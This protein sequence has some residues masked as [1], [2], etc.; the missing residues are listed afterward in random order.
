MLGFSLLKNSFQFVEIDSHNGNAV[1]QRF[2]KR[3]A[4]IPFTHESLLSNTTHQTFKE[5]INEA[6]SQYQLSGPVMVALD[7][8]FAFVKK[9][10]MDR[11]LSAEQIENQLNWEY[12]QIFPDKS[13]GD[14]KFVCETITN[15]FF[16]DKTTVLS[17]AFRKD[18]LEGVTKLFDNSQLEL[19]YLDLDLFSALNGIKHIYKAEDK[20]F[21]VLADVRQDSLKIQFVRK[22]EFFDFYKL[23]LNVED[24]EHESETFESDESLS[25]LLNKEIRRKLIEY[26]LDEEKAVDTLYLFGEKATAELADYLTIS[27]AR[28]VVLVEPFKMLE[29]NP[30]IGDFSQTVPLSS[31]Y[32]IS[33]GTALRSI[34]D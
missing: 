24:Q 18:I 13:L 10:L 14:Y 34:P 4:S 6:I 20:E 16:E 25:R 22:G 15:D 19:K 17:V 27:P 12:R 31:E 2:A 29:I 21:M 32:A 11:D 1:I 3:P 9:F 33:I 28:E 7:N 26:K 30:D 23:S 5:L 8:H